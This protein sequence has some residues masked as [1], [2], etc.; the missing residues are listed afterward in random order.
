MVSGKKKS[1]RRISKIC[2]FIF[3][4][5]RVQVVKSGLT[6]TEKETS[7]QNNMERFEIREQNKN[8]TEAKWKY[9]VRFFSLDEM[10]LFH[11]PMSMLPACKSKVA[12]ASGEREGVAATHS[13]QTED[14]SQLDVPTSKQS[15]AGCGPK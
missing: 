9:K 6:V 1:R 4:V 8:K 11:P 10:F 2:V 5:L 3:D 12:L 13:L 15:R 7:K 14:L